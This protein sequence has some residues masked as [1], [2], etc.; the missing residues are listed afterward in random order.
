MLW[1]LVALFVFGVTFILP[2]ASWVSIQG[3]RRRVHDL[4][5]TIEDQARSI[6]LLK[7]RPPASE[8][9][10]VA[11]PPRP[12]PP[13]VPAPAARPAPPPMAATAPPAAAPPAATP[14]PATATPLAAP[15]APTVESIERPWPDLP[16][17]PAAAPPP[18]Q[19]KVV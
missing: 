6:E 1:L 10:A 7:R 3:L 17:K 11:A 13:P 2:I 12:T 8:P 19:P 4:E 14:A 15:A 5:E 18:A 16:P 9:A